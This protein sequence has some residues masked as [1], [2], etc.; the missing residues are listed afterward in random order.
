ML[1]YQVHVITTGL[2]GARQP[3]FE[4]L[5]DVLASSPTEALLL[6]TQMAAS[7]CDLARAGAAQLMPLSAE[8]VTDSTLTT[9]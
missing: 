7:R 9:F 2:G 8:I 1:T 5:V 6:G 3:Q 4:H